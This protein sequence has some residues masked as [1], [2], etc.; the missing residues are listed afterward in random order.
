M[1]N[2]RR[3]MTACASLMAMRAVRKATWTTIAEAQ[4]K[5]VTAYQVDLDE[6]VK[7]FPNQADASSLPPL[8]RRFGGWMAGK[9]WRSIGAFDLAVRWSDLNL[10]GGEF[11]YDQFALFIKLPDGSSVGYWLAGG[12]LAQAPIVLLGSEGDYAT[13]APNLETLL[14]RIALGDFANKGPGADFLYWD[15]GCGEGVVPDLRGALQAFLREQMGIQDLEALARTARP[16]PSDFTQWIAQAVETHGVQMQAHSA[17]QA[18]ASILEKYRPVNAR[19]WEGPVINVRWAGAYFDAWIGP[20]KA[21]FVEAE[22]LK[23]HLAV[24]RDEAA[25][26]MPGLGLWHRATLTVFED[27]LWFMADYIYEPDFRSDKPS[28][29]DFEADHARSPRAVRRIPPWLATILAS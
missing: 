6:L 28:A 5:K 12:D 8:L 3:I 15:E 26:K 13:L 7:A 9:P 10:Q 17:I 27:N 18:M 20:G 1:L 21:T 4:E 19:P 11:Y 25:M 29:S 2:R 23:P 14:A 22:G 16:Y 24:L